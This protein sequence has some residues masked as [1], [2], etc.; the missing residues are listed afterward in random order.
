MG[1]LNEVNLLGR[2][3]ADPELRY[4]QDQTPVCTLS[5]A[6]SDVWT[7]K[8]GNK[9]EKTEWSRCVAWNKTAENASKYLQ[10]GSE[11]FVKG[12][13]ETRK[14]EDDKGVERY[15]T[16]IKVRNLQFVGGKTEGQGN[17]PPPVGEKQSVDTSHL[18]NAAVDDT[19]PF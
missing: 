3:G 10:K 4:T 19:I 14:W 1:N 17:R 8:E 9:Q 7:D 2:L 16:E 11:V 15:T 12:S 6:T 18:P 5:V 13:L